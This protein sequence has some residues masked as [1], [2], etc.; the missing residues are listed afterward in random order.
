VGRD[1]PLQA[2][3]LQP[4]ALQAGGGLGLR[5]EQ[6]DPGTEEYAVDPGAATVGEDLLELDEIADRGAD[7][8]AVELDQ[9]SAVLPPDRRAP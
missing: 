3:V 7:R 4:A 2:V 8:P 9:L 6:R 1:H 5:V